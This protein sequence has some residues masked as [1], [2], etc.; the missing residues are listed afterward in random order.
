[1]RTV[2]PRIL[3]RIGAAMAA[4]IMASPTRGGDIEITVTNDQPT[5]GFAL[6]PV[7]FG[8]QNGS[9][10]TFTPGSAAS[11]QLATLAQF[12]NTA[13]LSTLFESQHIGVDTTLTSGGSLV[14][15]LPGQWNSTIL[16]VGNPAVDEYL[17][18]AGMFVPSNDF[19]L[20]NATPLQIFNSNGTFKGPVTINIYASDI[21]DS[22][23]EQQSLTTALTFIQGQ[24]P[25]SGV[26]TSDPVTSLFSESTA[27]SFLQGIDG[28]T[29]AAGYVISHIP[30]SSDL[31]ATIQISSV[32]EP[33][34]I[35]M[36]GTGVL[37]ALFG[38]RKLRSRKLARNG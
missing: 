8:V 14:Q 6:A 34:S 1:M 37:G 9:F 26:Q 12:G 33:A 2:S 5:G 21:W 20:G 7:W 18:Y 29:T 32:P 25:G 22:G 36:L 30:T 24:T 3:I 17:S 28:K 4:I 27:T 31:I 16:T 15:Y 10:T 11:S 19:F 23:S 13:P 38:F 35:A